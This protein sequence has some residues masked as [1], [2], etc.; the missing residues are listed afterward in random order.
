MHT[1]LLEVVN[2]KYIN[3][4]IEENKLSF[5]IKLVFKDIN[6]KSEDYW[7]ELYNN[8]HENDK[9]C[10]SIQT[11]NSDI[12]YIKNIIDIEEYVNSIKNELI[13]FKEDE[14]KY[15]LKIEV[16][17]GQYQE[18]NIYNLEK[19]TKYIECMTLLE[20]MSFF[21]KI[22]F[23]KRRINLVFGNEYIVTE[24]FAICNKE[25]I[26]D[27][28]FTNINRED[29]ISNRN[30]NCAG[31]IDRQFDLLPN[32]FNI[33]SSSNIELKN[34]IDRLKL[35]SSLLFISNITTSIGADEIEYRI[36]G[37]KTLVFKVFN[38]KE[39]SIDIINE[40]YS[41]YKWV[42]EGA[43][44]SDKLGLSRNIIS[45]GIDENLNLISSN[46]LY[47]IKSSHEIYLKENIKEYIEVKSKV[48]EF[49]FDLNQKNSEIANM[50]SQGLNK[51]LFAILTFYSTVIIMNSLSDKKLNNIF[52]KDIT[53]FSIV[54]IVGSICYLITNI[55]EIYFDFQRHNEL[56]ERFKSNYGDILNDDDIDSIFNEK[57]NIEK[58]KSYIVNK[59]IIYSILWLVSITILTMVVFHLGYQYVIEYINII[60]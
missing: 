6:T 29:V 37:Y 9:V 25:Y 11:D 30:Y 17:K 57:N 21:Q 47:S 55:V 13:K 8:F 48:T 40:I 12:F 46:L 52:T 33:K 5:T 28:I 27:G 59:S 51:N 41:V 14:E 50:V 39:I 23:D 35:V 38:L 58:D 42:Y 26:L 24:T 32:D 19:F 7:K 45:L 20:Q 44:I 36:V 3:L 34:I 1:K 15:T 43:N 18:L 22:I 60:F 10:I 4:F 54:F 56:Y 31:V 2:G 49:L 53:L 16:S